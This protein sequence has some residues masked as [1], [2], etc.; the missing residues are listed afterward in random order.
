MCKC[1]LAAGH[2][3]LGKDGRPLGPIYRVSWKWDN[4][5]THKEIKMG[6][7]YLFILRA[8]P[9]AVIFSPQTR[10]KDSSFKIYR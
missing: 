2:L 1:D 6:T 10:P 7:D 9:E 4:W 8:G 5:F 3:L